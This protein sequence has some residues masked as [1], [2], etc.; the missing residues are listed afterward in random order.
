MLTL[1]PWRGSA[2]F[3][4]AAVRYGNTELGRQ[5]IFTGYR[6]PGSDCQG[7]PTDSPSY[8]GSRGAAHI[9]RREPGKFQ[10]SCFG[11]GKFKKLLLE[12]KK[13]QKMKCN[14]LPR[15]AACREVQWCLPLA[16][17]IIAPGS[18][19]ARHQTGAL[20]GR[21]P[22]WAPS[23]A[24]RQTAAGASVWKPASDSALS[25]AHPALPRL[26]R[27]DVN[28]Q[29]ISERVSSPVIQPPGRLEAA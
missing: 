22:H 7:R 21:R 25:H 5:L 10:K 28:C 11:L 6:L 9:R 13:S 29:G 19:S 1:K 24:P 17:L 2:N 4:R 20:S 27:T 3:R 8:L 15:P 26:L 12:S 14:R 16:L 23:R 18:T